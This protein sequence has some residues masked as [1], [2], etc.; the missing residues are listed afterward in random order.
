[1]RSVSGG[2]DCGGGTPGDLKD[3]ASCQPAVSLC[4]PA[5]VAVA[6]SGGVD[7]ST[8]AALLKQE[9]YQVI[10]LT[11]KLWSDRRLGSD[12][13]GVQDETP[14]ITD[15]RRVADALGIPHYVV[16]LQEEFRHCVVDYFSHEYFRGRTP[17]PCVVCNRK[18]KFGL[19]LSRAIELGADHLATGHYVRVR[20]D[21]LSHRY[22]L[23]KGVDS[24]KDQ[25]YVLYRLTQDQLSRLMFPLGDH[26]KQEVRSLAQQFRL[27]VATREESQEIC[28]IPD[29]DYRSFL[30]RYRQICGQ[31]VGDGSDVQRHGLI[32]DTAGEVLGRHDGI[33]RFT[34]GQRKGLGLASDERLYVVSLDPENNLVVVGRD[35]ELCSSEL[36][37]CDCNFVSVAAISDGVRV[38]AKIRYSFCPVEAVVKVDSERSDRV[39]V[40]FDE[41]VR[42][43]TPGQAVVL[44]S[45]D[46]LLGG[47]TIERAVPC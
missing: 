37:A 11:M 4:P 21:P 44:Y 40:V 23:L 18:I 32:V 38:Q 29:N 13:P 19:L 34:I 6:M 26:T 12:S 24:R 46:L 9:G 35:H 10:G 3:V 17:N 45:G 20:Y 2:T 33:E 31:R 25:S 27:P 41:P 36:V 15:A 1:M 47:G 8:V 43:V 7:S 42:A 39:R 5:T 14:A 16:D 30:R 22:A 28:F